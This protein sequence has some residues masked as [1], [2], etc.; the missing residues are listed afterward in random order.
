MKTEKVEYQNR[1]CKYIFSAEEMAEIATELASKTQEV[2]E[3]EAEK[4]SVAASYKERIERAQADLKAAA[5]KYKDAYE[6]RSIECFIERDFELGM[7]RYIRTDN[8]ELAGE[9]KMSMA[10]RQ[11]SLDDAIK[12]DDE[13]TDEEIRRQQNIAREMSTET[14]AL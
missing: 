12:T 8:G 1:H 10:E 9:S 13:P 11:M 4:K 7:V 5:R 3:L 6:M 2:D 14:S